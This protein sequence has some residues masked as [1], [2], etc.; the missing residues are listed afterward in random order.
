MPEKIGVQ[1]IKKNVKITLILHPNKTSKIH[2]ANPRVFWV[3]LFHVY[4]CTTKKYVELKS[5]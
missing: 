2:F 5:D 1:A 4:V 3:Y